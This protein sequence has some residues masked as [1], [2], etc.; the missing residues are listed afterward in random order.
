MKS[1]SMLVDA[2]TEHESGA[3]QRVGHFLKVRGFAKTIGELEGLPQDA[4]FTLEAA[5]IV[6][7][8]GIKLSLEKYGDSAGKHQEAEGGPATREL[9]R[10]LGFAAEVVERVAFLVERHHTYT[11]VDGLD[12]QILLEADLL[13]NIFEE[14]MPR[15]AVEAA[16]RDVIRTGAG[17]RICERL[18]LAQRKPVKA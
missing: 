9:L 3:P 11:G 4:L 17:R 15:A 8:I 16:C 7:D 18:Y 5:A 6:H 13:V 10:K 2:M 12:Y 1:L 14:E